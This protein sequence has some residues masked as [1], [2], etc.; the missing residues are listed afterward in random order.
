MPKVDY[1]KL[2][3][4]DDTSLR[5]LEESM[6]EQVRREVEARKAEERRKAKKARK[7]K[8]FSSR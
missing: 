5:E 3:Q 1:E 4:F 8:R 2:A 6:A 7:K